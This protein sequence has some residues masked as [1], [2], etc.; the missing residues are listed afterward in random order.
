MNVVSKE[1]ICGS[2]VGKGRPVLRG[3]KV[4]TPDPWLPPLMEYVCDQLRCRFI[5]SQGGKNASRKAAAQ[6][7]MLRHSRRLLPTAPTSIERL[8]RE[9]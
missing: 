6:W 8:Q 9:R 7:G 1:S 3:E 5:W 2:V 4:I